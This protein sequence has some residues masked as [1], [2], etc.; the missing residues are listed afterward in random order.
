MPEINSCISHSKNTY[1]TS[2]YNEVIGPEVIFSLQITIKLDKKYE[3]TV[4][5]HLDNTNTRTTYGS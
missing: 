2:G 5:M 1:S 4:F 3:L